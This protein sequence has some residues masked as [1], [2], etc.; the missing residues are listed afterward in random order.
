M[1]RWLPRVRRADA[2]THARAP[3]CI[4]GSTAAG[5]FQELQRAKDKWMADC[6]AS[7][8]AWRSLS[9]EVTRQ[10]LFGWVP[11]KE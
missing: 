10:R 6:C 4:R 7:G 5:S 11:R 2:V 8:R 3:A 1:G 9:A